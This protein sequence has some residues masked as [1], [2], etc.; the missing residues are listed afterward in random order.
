MRTWLLVL[1]FGAL[2]L[3]MAAPW[4]LHP[5]TRV[6]VDNPDTQLYIWTLGWDVHALTTRPLAIFD[7]NIF[8]PYA[9]TLAYS[10]NMI[11]SA[12]LAAPIAWLTGDLVLTLNV[13]LLVSC[14]LCGVGAAV[15]GR[16]LGLGRGAAVVTG[17][18]FAFA[19][20]RFFR[21]SQLHLDAVQWIPFA[22]AWFHSY[23]AEGRARDLRIAIAFV[24][25]QAFTSGHGAVMLIVALAVVALGRVIGGTPLTPLRRL[26]D[27]GLTGALTLVPAAALLL[28]YR[29]ARLEIGLDRSLERWTVTPESFLASPS[30]V[31]QYLLSFV[32]SRDLT[33]TASAFLFPG[34]VV[35][36]LGAVALWPWRPARRGAPPASHGTIARTDV[37]CYAAV[38]A[39][40]LAF[41]A[42][43]PLD[44]WPA[45]HTWPGFSFIRVPS[46]FMIL[47]TLALAVLAG[48]GAARVAAW[49]TPGRPALT[50]VVLSALLLVEYSP[51]PFTGDP[52]ALPVPTTVAWLNEQPRPFVVAEVPE[53]RA[54]RGGAYERFQTAAM[55]HT[56]G[57]WQKTVHGYSGIQPPDTARILGDLTTFPDDHSVATLREYGVTWVVVHRRLYPDTEWPTIDALVRARGDLHVANESADGLVVRVLGTP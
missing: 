41:F 21:M 52:F 17:I 49:A 2:T 25:L 36:V 5:A 57:H 53:P 48:A 32:T 39:L 35:L 11:G 31:H 8:D 16:R 15:L 19:P 50:G 9:N 45:V 55:L 30:V 7:A 20:T 43:G 10:E 29:R 3:V 4:S 1:L 6:V 24:S 12:L 33:A 22:L 23:L 56:T 13:V 26:R 42:G 18:V 28:P 34:Y 27:V 54:A 47:T 14:A 44:L 38:A 51:Y 37:W 40:S 46:R